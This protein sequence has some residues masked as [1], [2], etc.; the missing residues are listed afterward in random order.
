MGSDQIRTADLR[1]VP[2]AI[3]AEVRRGALLQLL[4]QS[5][6]SVEARVD[7]AFAP[8]GRRSL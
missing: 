7:A 4:F 8:H 5:F 3:P 6:P 2:V 1:D